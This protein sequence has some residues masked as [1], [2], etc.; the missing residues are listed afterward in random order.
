MPGIMPMR[1]MIVAVRIR[2]GPG[3]ELVDKLAADV[4]RR[5][6]R[7]SRMR[8]RGGRDDERRN[9]CNESVSHGQQGV[10]SSSRQSPDRAAYADDQA[11]YHIDEQDQHARYRIAP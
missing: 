2:P 3:K 6:R 9:L 8:A 4:R 11:A 7:G 5:F 10:V 1:P